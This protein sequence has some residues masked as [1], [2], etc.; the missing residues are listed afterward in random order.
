MNLFICYPKCSTCK[1]VKQFLEE[2][3]ISYQER[4]IKEEN[5]TKEEIKSWSIKYQIPI[6]KF[7]NTSG[8]L[9]R[10]LSL[11]DKL[12]FMSEEEQLN[13][14]GS[15]GMLV[16]RPIFIT[17]EKLIIGNSKKDYEALL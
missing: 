16:K 6:R 4:N 8:I 7:F 14:L 15:D 10:E 5:P 11:K 12:D 13:L 17:E 2:N 9:Y 3:N 1:K